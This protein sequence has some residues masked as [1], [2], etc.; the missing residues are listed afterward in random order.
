MGKGH[1][2]DKKLLGNR[3]ILQLLRSV[4][5]F[6]LFTV[7]ENVWLCENPLIPAILAVVSF[8]LKNETTVRT[9]AR[10]W[11]CAC[12]TR[13]ALQMTTQME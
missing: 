7:I 13:K 5:G 8:S 12:S 4:G 11:T 6:P 9:S 2:I 3:E 10:A 1:A